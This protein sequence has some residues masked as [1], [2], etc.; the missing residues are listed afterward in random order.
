[1]HIWVL[2]I[3]ACVS[4]EVPTSSVNDRYLQQGHPSHSSVPVPF[5][6]PS[7]RSSCLVVSVPLWRHS[8]R[9][10]AFKKA[11]CKA[12]L[13]FQLYIFHACMASSLKSQEGLFCVV[14]TF[15]VDMS[16]NAMFPLSFSKCIEMKFLGQN[17]KLFVFNNALLKAY[18]PHL[19]SMIL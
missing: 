14:Q 2:S 18:A 12:G 13:L 11:E 19:D 15:P 16:V 9:A 17:L 1:M 7:K 8:R 5:L 3:Y 4:A 6:D 10:S